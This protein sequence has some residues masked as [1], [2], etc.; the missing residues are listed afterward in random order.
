MSIFCQKYWDELNPPRQEENFELRISAFQWL[1]TNLPVFL[2]AVPLTQEIPAKQT[3]PVSWFWYETEKNIGTNQAIN[4]K[5]MMFNIFEKDTEN[6]ILEV[7]SALDSI[8]SS[9]KIIEEEYL[10]YLLLDNETEGVTFSEAISICESILQKRVGSKN[11][12][13]ENSYHETEGFTNKQNGENMDLNHKTFQINSTG[14]FASC[15]EAYKL[16]EMANSYLLKNDPHSPSPYLIR[17]A[18]EWRKKSLYG[19]FME[20]FTTTS[21]PQEI[22]TLLGLSHSDESNGHE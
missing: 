11:A 5:N 12:S 20:L 10:V 9:L 21:K 17:R 18:L 22:F 1:Q 4:A 3:L 14:H 2:K 15:D 16:I 6:N 7:Y 19:V 13:Y 8:L